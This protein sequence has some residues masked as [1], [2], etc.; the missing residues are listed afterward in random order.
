VLLSKMKVS[1]MLDPALQ[2][3][4]AAMERHHLFPKGYLQTLGIKDR[5]Y[6]NQIA[7]YALVEWDANI[8]ISDRAP[9]AY[10]AEYKDRFSSDEMSEMMDFHALP[11]G[12][13]KM[14]YMPFLEERRNR[15]AHII[16]RGF[17]T[18]SS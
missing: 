13:E 16:R 6:A 17:D 5:F 15:I 12:W 18:L 4:K 1:E 7:N 10:W 9:E 2:A 14:D 3:K 11:E 8:N